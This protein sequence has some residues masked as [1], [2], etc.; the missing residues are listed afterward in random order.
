MRPPDF[1]RNILWRKQFKKALSQRQSIRL[2]GG[3]WLVVYDG[4]DAQQVALARLIFEKQQASGC[5]LAAYEAQNAPHGTLVLTAENISHSKLPP[6]AML[7]EVQA[8][9]FMLSVLL[10]PNPEPCLQ[11]LMAIAH[12][13]R[14]VAVNPHKNND[15]CQ[16]EISWPECDAQTA[17]E[18]LYAQL[19]TYISDVV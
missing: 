14:T 18:R 4:R 19:K 8:K 15:L 16:L 1:I 11:Y 7:H 13:Y 10:A 6:P 3:G 9:H 2:A 17:F 5:M 12:S